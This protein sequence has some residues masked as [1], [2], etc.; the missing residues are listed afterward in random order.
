MIICRVAV[1]NEADFEWD[2]HA[3]ILV[4]AGFPAE[5]LQ[6]LKTPDLQQL[7]STTTGG[8]FKL[9]PKDL[10]ALLYT[11]EATKNVKVTSGTFRRLQAHFNHREIVEITATIGAYN[12]VSRFLVALDVDE[13]GN[14]EDDPVST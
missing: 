4:K 12:C 5:S 6:I 11:D 2:H 3:P 13:R 10:A 14:A 7:S 1:L 9:A 8:G